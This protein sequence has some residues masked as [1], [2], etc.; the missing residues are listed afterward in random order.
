MNQSAR[1]AALTSYCK[2]LAKAPLERTQ[3]LS[4]ISYLLTLPRVKK[5]LNIDTET[6]VALKVMK[7]NTLDTKL[8]K[9]ISALQML[10]HPNIANIIEILYKASYKKKNGKVVTRDVIVMELADKADLFAFLKLSF[11]L[12]PSGFPEPILRGLVRQLVEVVEYCHQNGIVHRD[13]KPEN[14]L[15]DAEYNIKLADFGWAAVIDNKYHKTIA[16]TK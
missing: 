3:H 6:L 14:I 12:S 5:A 15:L 4:R 11:N 9:E 10:K 8:E 16:G 1:H 2:R 7:P 13:I